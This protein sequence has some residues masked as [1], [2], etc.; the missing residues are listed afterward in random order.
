MHLGSSSTQTLLLST[1]VLWARSTEGGDGADPQVREKDLGTGGTDLTS[2]SDALRMGPPPP[3]VSPLPTVTPSGLGSSRPALAHFPRPCNWE[4]AP[5][6]RKP[7]QDALLAPGC[8]KPPLLGS[9]GGRAQP[10]P[11]FT[12]ALLRFPL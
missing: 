10:R 1:N 4:A 12:F 11:A 7:L 8:S 6:P 2:A 9:Q 3:A 5:A